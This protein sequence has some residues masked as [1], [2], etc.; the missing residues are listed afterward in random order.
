MVLLEWMVK[1]MAHFSAVFLGTSFHKHISNPCNFGSLQLLFWSHY[2]LTIRKIMNI[3]F[4]FGFDLI[5]AES[6][7]FS[8]GGSAISSQHN[9]DRHNCHP[10]IGN[11]IRICLKTILQFRTNWRMIFLLFDSQ[12]SGNKFCTGL[13]AFVNYQWN[14]LHWPIIDV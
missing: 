7:S 10:H 4:T 8:I 12:K 9:N 1:P 11:E 3:I 6:H 13:V 2:A 5:G 14:V